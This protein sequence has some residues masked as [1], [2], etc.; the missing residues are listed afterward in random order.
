MAKK[1]IA[2]SD[3]NADSIYR[4]EFIQALQPVVDAETAGSII[5]VSCTSSSIHAGFLLQQLVL[6][7]ERH[8][9][10]TNTVIY[11]GL[12]DIS[13][14]SPLFVIRLASG[15]V[16]VGENIDYVFSFVKR[17]MV[18]VFT[19][20]TTANKTSFSSR[21]IYAHI[22]ALLLKSAEKDMDLEQT[23]TNMVFEMDA[24]AVGHID[25]F[26]NIITTYTLQ[27]AK[28]HYEYLDSPIVSV[29]HSSLHCIFVQQPLLQSDRQLYI[30]PSSWGLP[31]NPYLVIAV[32]NAYN[33]TSAYSAFGKPNIGSAL[34][35][36]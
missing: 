18:E 9:N 25:V 19:Y 29:G 24:H 26:G 6:T 28:E 2:L 11:C 22:V 8:G 27:D 32:N 21:D 4:A 30:G 35:L 20:Q 36:R 10:P 13:G 17:K 16:V 34:K 3:W 7:E 15:I 31:S 14:H 23:H 12:E 5:H 1:L 33:T